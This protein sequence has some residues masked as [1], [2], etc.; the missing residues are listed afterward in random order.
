MRSYRQYCAVAKGLDMV[1]DRWSLL[2]V[3]ELLISGDSRYTDLRDGIPG[4][5]T[6]LLADRLRDLE[7]AGVITRIEAPPPVATAVFRL[8]PWGEG[9]REVLH[10]LGAWAGPLLRQQSPSDVLQSH[11]LA[12]PA[13]LYLTDHAPDQPPVTLEVRT[14]D[15]PMHVVPVDGGARMR[16][17][18]AEDPDA[19]LTGEPPVVLGVLTGRLPLGT[20]RRMGGHYRGDPGVLRRFTPAG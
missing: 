5:A 20:A 4:I 2:I 1:G 15:E 10:A 13:E 16:R 12:I 3:R 9:L 19:V 11:W 17:G 8:T 18:A 14:G 7:A 6:N